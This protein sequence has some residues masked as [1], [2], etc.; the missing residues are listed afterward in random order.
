MDIENW[1]IIFHSFL[2]NELI[3]YFLYKKARKFLVS[4][5]LLRHPER[6]LAPQEDKRRV[7]FVNLCEYKNKNTI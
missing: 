3:V 7:A 5:F 2:R 4:L 1:K 6:Q